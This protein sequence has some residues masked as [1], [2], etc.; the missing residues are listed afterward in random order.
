MRIHG[1][2]EK[3]KSNCTFLTPV[4]PVQMNI[5]QSNTYRKDAYLSHFQPISHFYLPENIR[6]PPEVEQWLKMG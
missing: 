1:L 3:L 2:V 5:Y 4:E 6:K